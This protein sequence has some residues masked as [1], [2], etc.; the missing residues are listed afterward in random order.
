MAVF[1][2]ASLNGHRLAH[3][4]TTST[5]QAD[6]LI[7]NLDHAVDRNALRQLGVCVN[8]NAY[9][10]SLEDLHFSPAEL[11]QRMA[12][13]DSPSALIDEDSE[14]FET[15]TEAYRRI[16]TQQIRLLVLLRM[17]ILQSSLSPM[18]LGAQSEWRLR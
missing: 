8:Y 6:K 12:Q 4:A 18:L 7:A 5:L 15:L 13:F 1:A 9:G 14:L 3:L 11:Y 17:M 10:A 16:C 2:A